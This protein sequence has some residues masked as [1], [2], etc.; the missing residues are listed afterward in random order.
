MKLISHRGN[1]DGKYPQYENLPEYVD[2]ALSLGY[3]VEVDL[4]IDNDG[5][6]LGHDEPTYP[7]N[8]KWL[9][10]RYLHLWIHCKDLRTLSEMRELQ[11]EISQHKD[12]FIN[13]H[14]SVYNSK[15]KMDL[16]QICSKNAE[17]CHHIKEQQEAD[18]NGMI[19]NFHKNSEHNLVPLCESCHHKVHHGNLRIHGYHMTNEGKKLNYE[20]IESSQIQKNKKFSQNDIDIILTYKD[21]IYN[22]TLKK[23]TCMNML[24][25]THNIHISPGTFN[26]IISGKY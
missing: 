24:K 1:V 4:W 23:S 16:C 15:I 5:Y 25:I 12:T 6:Y 3:D 11:L 18:E 7:I 2:K 8:L 14:S 10:D 22:K 26:K 17:H 21:E 20:Y 13:L 19:D 9:T